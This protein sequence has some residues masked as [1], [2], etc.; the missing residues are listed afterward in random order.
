LNRKELLLGIRLKP[1]KL[2]PGR[3]VVSLNPGEWTSPFVGKGF[4]TRGFR[5]F[6]LG[7]D[8][9]SVHLATSVRRGISTVIE[10]VA[11]RDLTVVILLDLSP[12]MFVRNKFDAQMVAAALL[13]YSSWQSETTFGLAIHDGED[14]NSFGCSIGTRHFYKVYDKLWQLY[15]SK[16]ADRSGLGRKTHLR[17]SF[18]QNSIIF[19][20]SDYLQSGG[21]LVDIIHLWR[22]TYR[23]DFIPVVIQDDFEYT[24]PAIKSGTFLNFENP[25]TGMQDEIWISEKD[26]KEVKQINESRFQ[27]LIHLFNIND[28]FTIH[29]PEADIHNTA[30]NF[31]KFFEQRK[32]RGAK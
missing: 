8:P 6:E 12:S 19:Y 1:I 4:E 5:D 22:Q 23:Y 2:I 31:I 30:M 7:D 13:L 29:I 10:R 28:T 25:E 3:R 14:I 20:I 32:R 15:S 16:G 17:R 27:K 11:L 24:F 21:E 26:S 18:P 9:R